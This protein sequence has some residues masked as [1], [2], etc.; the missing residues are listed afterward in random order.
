MSI[1]TKGDF[2]R[3]QVITRAWKDPAFKNKLLKNPKAALQECGCQLP[4]KINV[5]VVE[6]ERVP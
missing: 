1:P 5:Q 6:E 4:D 2:K 3:G